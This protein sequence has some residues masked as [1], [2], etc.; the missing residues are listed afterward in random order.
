[1]G[2][3]ERTDGTCRRQTGSNAQGPTGNRPRKRLQDKVGASAPGSADSDPALPHGYPGKRGF[4][5]VVLTARGQPGPFRSDRSVASERSTGTIR[6]Y[7]SQAQV[8][9]DGY[10]V[11]TVRF[12]EKG[13]R[14]EKLLLATGSAVG[15]GAQASPTTSLSAHGTGPTGQAVP[16]T[17]LWAAPSGGRRPSGSR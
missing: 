11:N 9:G 15:S 12:R 16:A 5:E 10:N 14:L 1:M 17:H 2:P 4:P 7:V 13:R 6:K 3:W 8:K